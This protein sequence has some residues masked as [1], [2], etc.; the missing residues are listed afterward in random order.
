MEYDKLNTVQKINLFTYLVLYESLI[1]QS[2]AADEGSDRCIVST[3]V[4][5]ENAAP[6]I[7]TADEYSYNLLSKIA[8]SQFICKNLQ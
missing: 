4:A 7:I 3:A 8:K 6:S 5:K 2:P 1:K